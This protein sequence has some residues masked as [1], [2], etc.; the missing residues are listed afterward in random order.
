VRHATR[1]D[2]A[3][4]AELAY[5]CHLAQALLD[6]ATVGESSVAPDDAARRRH[7]ARTLLETASQATAVLAGPLYTPRYVNAAWR[8]LLGNGASNELDAGLPATISELLDRVYHEGES[9]SVI[10]V[11]LREHPSICYAS[12]ALEPLR[13]PLGTID[14]VIAVCADVTDAAIA[15]KLGVAAPAVAWSGPIAGS[16][17]YASAGWRQYTG[18]ADTADW[19]EAISIADRAACLEA[20]REAFGHA[21]PVE[22]TVGIKR[23]NG[24]PRRHRVRIAGAADGKRWFAAAIDAVVRDVT[25][26]STALDMRS[27]AEHA[28]R[29]K[30][31][32]IARISHELRGALATMSL[33]DG[34]LRRGDQDAELRRQALDAIHQSVLLQ[35]TL[36]ADLFDIS[37]AIVG[38]LRIERRELDVIRVLGDAV[39][40]IA[41]SALA[42]QITIER[43]VEPLPIY[44]LGDA[45]RLRQVFDNVL[46]NA[47][48]FT[49][50]GGRISITSRR[51]GPVLS[52][53]ISDNGH[54]IDEDLLP[55]LF[56]AFSQ[57]ENDPGISEERGLGLGLA[58]A[59]QLV[60][61]HDGTLE[62][63]SAGRGRGSVF[64]V[65]LPASTTK[66][67]SSPVIHR[68]RASLTGIQVLIT[69]DDSRLREA[70]AL[71]LARA[72]ALVE[73]A[74]SAAAA[75]ACIAE[76]QFDVLICD[77]AMPI[78]DGYTLI[79]KL[80]S[81]GNR[82]PAIALTAHASDADAQRARSA[83]FDLHLGKPV[84]LDALTA[85]LHA[86]IAARTA[87]PAHT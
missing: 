77:I 14:G 35:S 81:D 60:T 78:E 11:E 17:D 63:A 9:R 80:R 76:K 8:T 15:R 26:S 67:A 38:K 62:A 4:T 29:Q 61:L 68:A 32:F 55:R 48:K 21:T 19:L 18:M 51:S 74:D 79:R 39:D 40:A 1:G 12:L 7:A 70:L 71:L 53:E 24:A 73:T 20:I 57:S 44:V 36:V 47:L 23:A 37:R 22:L 50:P 27:D 85:S 42:R 25:R 30:D 52:I 31:Q 13:G 72:G 45:I 34:V 49:D 82:T 65:R 56:D 86:V 3:I 83:G 10:D 16:A 64:T 5:A 84:D 87:E 33:W 41:P 28:G 59:Y 43:Q 6:E 58:I 75:R 46:A 66:R 54:G 69:D 2:E